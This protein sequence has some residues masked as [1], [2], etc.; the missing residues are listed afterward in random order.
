MRKEKG[1]F[2]NWAV[3]L[4]ASPFPPVGASVLFSHRPSEEMAATRNTHEKQTDKQ[5]NKVIRH[6]AGQFT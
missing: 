4:S 6:N 1:C 5:T 3:T 2:R